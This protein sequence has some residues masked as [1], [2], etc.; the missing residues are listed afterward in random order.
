MKMTDAPIIK[1]LKDGK[2]IICKEYGKN[3]KDMIFC[4]RESKK[5]G[6]LEFVVTNTLINHSIIYPIS[7]EML[8]WEWEIKEED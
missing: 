1:A 3:F 5:S 6:A 2:Y 8:T 4:V 7:G